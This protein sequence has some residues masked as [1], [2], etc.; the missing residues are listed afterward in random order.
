M[1]GPD[2]FALGGR[3]D[4]AE[5]LTLFRQ[6][7]EE[8]RAVAKW[9]HENPDDEDGFNRLCDA[10]WER[11]RLMAAVP[12]A[13]AVGLTIKVYLLTW[14]ETGGSC[15]DAPA[16][17]GLGDDEYL[18]TEIWRSLVRDLPAFVPELRPLVAEAVESPLTLPEGAGEPGDAA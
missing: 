15:R 8:E 7:V 17:S 14:L 2:V 13:S 3:Q 6:W 1:T 18:S 12:A 11:L 16:L 10:S 5:L 4:D 9:G